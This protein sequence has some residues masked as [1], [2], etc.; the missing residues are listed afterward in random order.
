MGTAEGSDH[1]GPNG[2]TVRQRFA[3]C[4]SPSEPFLAPLRQLLYGQ[5]DSAG[6]RQELLERMPELEPIINSW[7]PPAT[8]CARVLAGQPVDQT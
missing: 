1:P 6:L 2:K 5:P 8:D 3:E 4:L 7:A